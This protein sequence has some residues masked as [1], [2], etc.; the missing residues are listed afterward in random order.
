MDPDPSSRQSQTCRGILEAAGFDDANCVGMA[1]TTTWVPQMDE[2]IEALLAEI[3]PAA[4]LIRLN[5]DYGESRR[6]E[7]AEVLAERF[8]PW[9]MPDGTV[10]GRG[11]VWAGRRHESRIVPEPDDPSS[12]TAGRFICLRRLPADRQSTKPKV[13]GSNPVGRVN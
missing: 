6:P 13:T 8:G 2:A 12:S 3:G 7:I 10:V 1:P 9:Q 4:E 11:S 5:G